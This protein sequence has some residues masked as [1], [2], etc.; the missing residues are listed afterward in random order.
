[1]RVPQTEDNANQSRQKLKTERKRLFELFLKNPMHTPLAVEIKVIDD[2]LAE[3]SGQTMA[4]DIRSES[5]RNAG[6]K[7]DETNATR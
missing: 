2:R 7:G 6:T 4:V 5:Q 1:M 3:S